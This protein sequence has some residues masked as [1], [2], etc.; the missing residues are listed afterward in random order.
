MYG[1]PKSPMI[2]IT[3]RSPGLMKPQKQPSWFA[4][5]ADAMPSA[6]SRIG[7]ASTTSVAR[8]MIVSIL[9]R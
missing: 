2:K 1:Q 7:S 8:E 6:S 9:P 4:P 3:G 5:Q